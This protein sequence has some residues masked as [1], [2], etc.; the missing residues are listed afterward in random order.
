MPRSADGLEGLGRRMILLKYHFLLQSRYVSICVA[1]VFIGI[2]DIDL[3]YDF[4]YDFVNDYF[5]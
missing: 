2:F 4:N 1:D 5:N 3:L